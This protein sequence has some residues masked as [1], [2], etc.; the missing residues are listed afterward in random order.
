MMLVDDLLRHGE[1]EA[2]AA[3]LGREEWIEDAPPHA[4]RARPARDRPPTRSSC[5][6][7]R[8]AVAVDR[9]DF[10]DASTAL[11]STLSSTCLMRVG[12]AARRR[13][14]ARALTL[15]LVLRRLGAHQRHRLVDDDRPDRTA[16]A[17]RA[18]AARTCRK[19]LTMASSRLTSRAMACTSPATGL[20]APSSS[21]TTCAAAPIDTSGLRTSCAMRAAISPSADKPLGVQQAR[22]QPLALGV[23]APPLGQIVHAPDHARRPLLVVGEQQRRDLGDERAAVL[24]CAACSSR[25]ANPRAQRLVAQLHARAAASDRRRTV[26]DGRARAAT[27][28]ASRARARPRR[29]PTRCA[30]RRRA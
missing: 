29:C 12:I 25:S 27:S 6:A 13:A 4:D 3:R 7:D 21:A 26:L 5:V 10:G 23:A 19:S 8:C 22:S 1:P 30:R 11:S 9:A 18:A 16:A 15:E 28:A 14:A 20:A 2:G 24:A 17:R